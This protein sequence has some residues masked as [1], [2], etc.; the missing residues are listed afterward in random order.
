MVTT[1]FPA[2]FLLTAEDRGVY[3][4]EPVYEICASNLSGFRLEVWIENEIWF[5]LVREHQP[6][7][8]GQRI[9]WNTTRLAQPRSATADHS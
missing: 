9:T 7:T 3:Q 2:R 6:L 5:A 8:P 4:G 1:D